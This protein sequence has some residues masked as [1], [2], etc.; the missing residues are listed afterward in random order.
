MTHPRRQQRLG[1]A[2]LARRR[3]WFRSSADSGQAGKVKSWTLD[4]CSNP[5][6]SS[7]RA[8]RSF[9]SPQHLLQPL[10]RQPQRTFRLEQVGPEVADVF[11]ALGHV[12][13]GETSRRNLSAFYF[14]PGAGR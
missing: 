3:G 6:V 9:T 1:S 7:T 12:A 10:D 14:L 4:L 5:T 13:D 2:S 8:K 11:Y